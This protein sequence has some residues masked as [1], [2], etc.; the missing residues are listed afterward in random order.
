MCDNFDIYTLV[1]CIYILDSLIQI[2][3]TMV[4]FC[5]FITNHFKIKIFI[6]QHNKLCGRAFISTDKRIYKAILTV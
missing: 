3:E 4:Q 2:C 1:L 5:V 6:N